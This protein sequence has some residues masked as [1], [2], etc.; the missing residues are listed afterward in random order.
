MLRHLDLFSGIGGFALGLARAGGY[1][2]VGQRMIVA[3][4][5][6]ASVVAVNAAWVWLPGSHIAGVYWHP[7][8]VLAGAVFVVRDF[9]QRRIGHRVLFWML[10]G[11]AISYWA[12]SPEVALA[13]AAA[14]AVSETADWL[15]YTITGRPFAERVLLSSVIGTPI[16]SA[17]FLMLV[18]SWSLAAAVLMTITK[19][20]VALCAWAVVRR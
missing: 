20:G 13:S 14:F 1:E 11:A 15:V 4:A 7:A 12:A 10:A 18:G 6:L 8:M 3:V 16:D 19:L 2:T 17:L 5:Y 9:A